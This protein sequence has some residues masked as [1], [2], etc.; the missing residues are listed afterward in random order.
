LTARVQYGTFRQYV[1]LLGGV[2]LI[3]P[4]SMFLLTQSQ[5]SNPDEPESVSWH[6][7]KGCHSH[8]VSQQLTTR[9]T[10]VV[11]ERVSSPSCIWPRERCML[12]NKALPLL[13]LPQC[14]T[15]RPKGGTG[16]PSDTRPRGDPLPP[17]GY[18]YPP[19]T[20]GARP[21]PPPPQ[22][23]CY[24]TYNLL[25]SSKL[26]SRGWGLARQAVLLSGISS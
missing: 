8:R 24:T 3:L 14:F 17:R 19:Y 6:P 26:S 18:G 1:G 16:V 10:H 20:P 11:L 15:T 9:L 13:V 12:S 5:F 21:P 2:Y 23:S 4:H 7:L 22:G 25:F